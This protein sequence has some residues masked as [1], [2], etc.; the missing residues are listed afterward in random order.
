MNFAPGENPPSRDFKLNKEDGFIAT[1]DVV[2][3]ET[4]RGTHS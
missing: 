2:G 1:A 3:G 4:S